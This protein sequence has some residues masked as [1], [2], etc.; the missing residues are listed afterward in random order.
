MTLQRPE[1][2][3]ETATGRIIGFEPIEG[4][5]LYKIK[6]ADGKGGTLPKYCDGAFT[7]PKECTVAIK[8]FVN[9]TFAVAEENYK[10]K[11]SA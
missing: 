10:G 8:R 5:G 2:P 1:N 3:N 4:T 7:S 11:K 6:Y 9:D